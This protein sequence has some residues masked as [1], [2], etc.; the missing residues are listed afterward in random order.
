M[1][2]QRDAWTT[3]SAQKRTEHS[4]GLGSWW[5]DRHGFIFRAF[6]VQDARQMNQAEVIH[7]GWVHRDHPIL[8]LLDVGQADTRDS[9]LLDV[10]L[11]IDQSRSA[12]GGSGHSFADRQRRRNAAQR[13]KAH[14]IGKE[15]FADEHKKHGLLVDPQSSRRPSRRKKSKRNPKKYLE[16]SEVNTTPTLQQPDFVTPIAPQMSSAALQTPSQMLP[17]YALP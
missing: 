4:S 10:E 17:Q 8:S 15:I 7:N 5:H 1:N 2:L 12:S 3:S 9:L 6:T 11:K 16:R 14:S 13:N